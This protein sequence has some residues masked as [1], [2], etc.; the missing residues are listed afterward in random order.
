MVELLA[1]L[2]ERYALVTVELIFHERPELTLRYMPNDVSATITP[3]VTGSGEMLTAVPVRLASRALQ[4]APEVVVWNNE[5]EFP[6]GLPSIAATV[7]KLAELVD[8]VTYAFPLPSIARPY[9]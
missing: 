5:T 2:R 1:G 4:E 9:R 7:G 6:E 8:P 3:G